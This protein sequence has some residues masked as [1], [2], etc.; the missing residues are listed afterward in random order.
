MISSPG[1]PRWRPP[2]TDRALS[3]LQRD[4]AA[5]AAALTGAAAG[6]QAERIRGRLLASVVR[7]LRQATRAAAAE[8]LPGGAGSG[9]AARPGNGGAAAKNSAPDLRDRLWGLAK[10]ATRLRARFPEVAELAEATAALQD[11]AVGLADEASAAERVAE[12]AE[13]QAGL[14]TAIQVM[15]DGP[16]LVTN[17]D[18]VTDWLGCPLPVRPQLALCRCAPR[19][20]GRCATAATQRSGSPA[21]RTRPVCLTAATPTAGSR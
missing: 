13:L 20:S 10:A 17:A 7:P 14:G 15:T 11:L 6:E 8:A 4:V 2:R 9:Q 3:A 18:R 21:A 12:L 1:G 19:R 5:A 16:Y